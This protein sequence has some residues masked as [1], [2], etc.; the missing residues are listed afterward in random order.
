M[1]SLESKLSNTF[2]QDSGICES[3][4]SDVDASVITESD[5]ECTQTA[6]ATKEIVNVIDNICVLNGTSLT[7]GDR[8]PPAVELIDTDKA[9]VITEDSLPP[10]LSEDV[11][12]PQAGFEND[13]VSES[14]PLPPSELCPTEAEISPPATPELAREQTAIPQDIM[15]VADKM[16]D[17]IPEITSVPDVSTITE[18]TMD[19]A[20]D[21]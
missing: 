21:N 4:S 10:S 16:A 14:F 8:T 13:E 3:K 2:E 20:V 6:E 11:E 12:Q 9:V 1:E 15:P 18:T 17:L 19:V 7:N 5:T